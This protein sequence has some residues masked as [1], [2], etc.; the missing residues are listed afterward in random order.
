MGRIRN[1]VPRP[2]L[3]IGRSYLERVSVRCGHH[4]RQTR[5][6]PSPALAT[7]LEFTRVRSLNHWPKSDIS[8]FGWRAGV[9]ADWHE[10]FAF[11]P[12]LTLPRKRGR[13]RTECAA[14]FVHQPD[15]NM[16]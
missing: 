5:S 16:V 7:E 4:E 1:T 10:V 13:E 15:R 8:D 6:A 14:R 11:A 2:C 3:T 12:T 9:G